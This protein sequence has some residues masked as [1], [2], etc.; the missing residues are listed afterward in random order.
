MKTD[1]I[2]LRYSKALF[3][4]STTDAELQTRLQEILQ[5]DA[6]LKQSPTLM[7]FFKSPQIPM[8]QKKAVMD[9]AFDGNIDKHLKSF[10]FLLLDKRRFSY[11]P[12]IVKSYSR[13][14]MEKLGILEARIIT[15]VPIQADDKKRLS[16]KLEQKYGKKIDLIEEVDPKIIGGGILLIGNEQIDFSISGKLAK[17]KKELLSVTV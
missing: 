16:T 4:V 6:L 8:E 11:F 1:D 12:Q 5:I 13:L 17:L 9:K 7:L 15:A 10:L 3:N 14:V 2:A